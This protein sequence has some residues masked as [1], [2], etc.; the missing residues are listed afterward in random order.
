MRFFLL[1]IPVLLFFSF[2]EQIK[3]Q[4]VDIVKNADSFFKP[5]EIHSNPGD[6]TFN[7]HS[8]YDIQGKMNLLVFNI[9]GKVVHAENS[10]RFTNQMSKIDLGHLHKGIYF[11]QLRVDDY[12][13]T[14][15]LVKF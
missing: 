12:S 10:V 3:I 6:D 7:L 8:K 9:A 5:F 13:S 11:V 1:L 4:K 14:K 2:R 15:K